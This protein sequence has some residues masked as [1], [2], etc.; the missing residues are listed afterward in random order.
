MSLD[1]L[2][3]ALPIW[4]A[5]MAGT[6]TPELAAAVSEAGGFGQLGLAAMT[7]AKA[8]EAMA[9]THE[10]T[11]RGF[12]ANLFCHRAD[13]RAPELE[14]DWLTRLRPHFERFDADPPPSLREIYRSFL[15][16]DGSMLTAVVEGRPALVSFHF[17]LP[18]ARQLEAL[19]ATG[20]K[21]AATAT[22]LAEASAIKAAGLDAIIAQGWQAGGH[23]GIFDP[24]AD[25]ERLETLDLVGQ[26][27]S[28]GLPV[29]AA[30]AIMTAK[31]V[32]AALA[33][34]AIAVQCGTA[35][36]RAPEAATSDAHREV[37]DR[38]RTVMTK[39][40]SGRP[41]RCVENLFTA[42]PDDGTPGYP[43]TFDAGKALNA[44]AA[45]RGEHG[46]GA[47]WAGTGCAQSVAR[48]A[49][50][51]VRALAESPAA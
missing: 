29:I 18:L 15:D 32:R 49:A 5:P 22:S 20:A 25:D 27:A 14:A 13:P 11:S 9:E 21:L 45:E 50:A 42:I 4:Q 10:R 26:F 3:A 35:F 2:D 30:G 43:R 7:P 48:S 36:L 40:I 44:A 16:D 33:A 51:T 47:Q 1:G 28:L 6:S 38:G 23:R 34:G 19:R 31:D 46:Y 39:A 24:E 41:A 37:L 17:G 12:G 8:A